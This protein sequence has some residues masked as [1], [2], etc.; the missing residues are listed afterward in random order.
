MI[1]KKEI[2][3]I[4]I[5]QYNKIIDFLDSIYKDFNGRTDE[6]KKYY[7]QAFKIIKEE[8]INLL[9]SDVFWLLYSMDKKYCEHQYKDGSICNNKINIKCD[10]NK[11]KFRCYDHISKTVYE[12]EKRK[13]IDPNRICIGYRKYGKQMIPCKD[14]KMK[15]NNYCRH[16]FKLPEKVTLNKAYYNYY[17]NKLLFDEI[18]KEHDLYLKS[19]LLE[20]EIIILN[21]IEY[22]NYYLFNDIDIKNDLNIKYNS[23]ICLGDNCYNNLVIY[24]YAIGNLDNFVMEVVDINSFLHIKNDIDILINKVNE[25]IKDVNISKEK[26]NKFISKCNNI[27]R[28][29][30]SQIIEKIG[31]YN[32]ILINIPKKNNMYKI[33]TNIIKNKIH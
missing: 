4:P 19:I 2:N 24:D 26:N 7:L 11:G 10:V 14:L 22:D 29:L 23:S 20:K 30:D 31:R 9:K 28:N 15:N 8:L 13:K 27:K 25:Y 16:H 18:K 32:D 12:S 21:N 1:S 17:F 33:V 6:N 5:K 3:I